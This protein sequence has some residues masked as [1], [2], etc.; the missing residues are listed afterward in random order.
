MALLVLFRS[1]FVIL[2]N[3][4]RRVMPSETAQRG[5]PCALSKIHCL[6][7]LERS[8]NFMDL[9]GGLP[10]GISTPLN[11]AQ[12]ASCEHQCHSYCW[13]CSGSIIPDV[14]AKLSLRLPMAPVA[15][16]E[17]YMARHR[18]HIAPPFPHFQHL[19]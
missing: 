19:S 11:K 5:S 8:H 4:C 2:L 13:C 17:N 18:S 14:L 12:D 6:K 9:A 3:V 7:S 1:S 15:P 16:T 10:K